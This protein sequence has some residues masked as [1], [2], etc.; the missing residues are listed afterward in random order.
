M[1]FL[2]ERALGMCLLPLVLGSCAPGCAAPR[3][4]RAVWTQSEKPPAKMPAPEGFGIT[5]AQ[6]HEVAWAAGALSLKHCWAIYA[7]S[8]DYYVDDTFFG[9]GP[10]QASRRGVRIDGQTGEIVKR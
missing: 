5:P 4:L 7:D 8:R 3:D 6:A 10:W 9:S 1:I 2:V